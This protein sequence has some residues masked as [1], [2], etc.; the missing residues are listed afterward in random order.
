M[1]NEW[2]PFSCVIRQPEH[3]PAK[4][5]KAPARTA[6]ERAA[7]AAAAKDARRGGERRR[8]TACDQ[9]A[10]G[11]RA[12]AQASQ[13]EHKRGG[14]Q[15]GAR[16][17]GHRAAQ[18]T[19]LPQRRLPRHENRISQPHGSTCQAQGRCPTLGKRLSI[20]TVS[21]KRHLFLFRNTFELD[22]SDWR[23]LW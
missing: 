14:L 21:I 5:A 1:Y 18:A 16:G 3:L 20:I 17:G 13:S 9:W 15:R 12:G 23:I 10:R 7:A 22:Y 6:A 2:Q 11:G 8:P 4:P 19:A